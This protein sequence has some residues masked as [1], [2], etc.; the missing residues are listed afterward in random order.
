MKKH[1]RN[2]LLT[3]C[4]VAVLMG[5][6]GPSEARPDEDPIPGTNNPHTVEP[7][8]EILRSAEQ[9]LLNPAVT[10]DDLA[11]QARASTEF[12]LDL[13]KQLIAT[14]AVD[15]NLFFSPHSISSALAMTSAG[16]RGQTLQD[17]E[18]AL[19]FELDQ[20]RLHPFF[21]RVDLTLASQAKG[22]EKV[23]LNVVNAVWGQHDVAVVPTFLDTLARNYGAGMH[24]LNFSD[25]PEGSR[26]V[27]NQWVEFKTEK[28]IKQLLPQG[29]I[30]SDTR[31]VLTNAIY[32]L[33]D[34]QSPFEAESTRDLAF[35]R[36]DNT[37]VNVPM[38]NQELGLAHSVSEAF[39]AVE[40]P[41]AGGDFSMVLIM[42]APGQLAAFEQ[43][44][45]AAGLADI[46]A[47]L[48]HDYVQLNLPKFEL[49]SAFSLK[50]ALVALGMESAFSDGA[51][52]SGISALDLYITDVIHQAVVKV[53]EKGTEA[54]AATAVI[55]GRE[56]AS[57]P[58]DVVITLN[59][60]FLS[61]IRDRTTNTIL[62][63][64]RV[65]DPS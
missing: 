14:E 39:T 43:G 48:S 23:T 13:Y 34:W 2:R 4:T 32:L 9:R 21:N 49:K 31:F 58:P 27:I 44:L 30:S 45:D 25:D 35:N 38:M 1:T 22:Q 47:G 15:D 28:L 55:I 11:A 26:Q 18:A 3:L 65:V 20:A 29:V 5:A 17:M 42:P 40:L 52:F 16:A 37:S 59:R 62:F 6:C 63:L 61:V 53:D 56:S 57:L 8:L 54:A 7:E 12:S 10:P 41:Y 19:G 51:D 60:P 64:G 46:I 50:D 24:L 36:L 33:A